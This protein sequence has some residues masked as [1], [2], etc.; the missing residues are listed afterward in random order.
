ME[1]RVGKLTKVA[2]GTLNSSRDIPNAPAIKEKLYAL[3]SNYKPDKS[4]KFD[5][6]VHSLVFSSKDKTP[7]PDVVL[8]LI[9]LCK[10]E[11]A[12]DTGEIDDVG[13]LVHYHVGFKNTQTEIPA[14]SK[15]TLLRTVFN[16]GNREIYFLDTV[17]NTP[18]IESYV[19]ENAR[20]K[21]TM[22]S[23][24]RQIM[25]QPDTFLLLGASAIATYTIT[26]RG[27]APDRTPDSVT[28]D[29][30]KQITQ[31]RFMRPP[32]YHRITLVVDLVGNEKQ[33]ER[34]NEFIETTMK[35]MSMQKMQKVAAS[36]MS[37]KG[38]D[39]ELTKQEKKDVRKVVQSDAQ[40]EEKE[41]KVSDLL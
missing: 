35:G 32:S 7:T 20:K 2:K 31:T 37:A 40:K 10:R 34:V 9:N 17:E 21:S 33:M 15:S 4:K 19:P 29:R 11:F 41:E 5:D 38:S 26:I 1:A 16:F 12:E 30:N 22:G 6:R 39:T 18:T 8:D 3:S 27:K 28:H 24:D 36:L 23:T 25:L 13:H 14:P